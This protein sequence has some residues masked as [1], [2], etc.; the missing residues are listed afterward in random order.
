MAVITI[1]RGSYSRG[2]E[3]AEKIADRLGYQ[4]IS[5]DLLLEVSK[6]Y[7]IPEIKLVHAIHDAPGILR[8]INRKNEKYI[9]FIKSTLL[10]H[11]KEDNIVYHGL[12]G[13]F[14]VKDVPHA[15]KV[16]VLS[17]MEDRIKLEM[18]RKDIDAERARRILKKDDEERRNW[19]KDLYGI[20]T[21]DP[22]LYDLVL[23]IKQL[24]VD[25]AVDMI[26]DCVSREQFQ[27][28][29]KSQRII[30]DLALSAAIQKV[31]LD[32]GA[33]IKVC[34]DNKV[35][36]I[37]TEAAV[38]AEEEL[39]KEIKEIASTFDGISDVKIQCHP[40]VALSE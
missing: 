6:E 35:A 36:F 11:L 13:H 22:S 38:G 40:I 34:V 3:I 18:E 26:C 8:R 21:A 9:A 10:N 12:A 27:T 1:S 14:F 15:L 16:R 31:L 5:R 28:T 20:D 2:K 24:T 17:D 7:N 37:E 25:D 4:C 23:H 30:D 33:D 39:I 29:A 19:S 32:V